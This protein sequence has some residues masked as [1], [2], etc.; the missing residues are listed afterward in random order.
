MTAAADNLLDYAEWLGIV[1]VLATL[2]GKEA[3][4]ASLSSLESLPEGRLA[5]LAEVGGRSPH[6]CA[7][8]AAVSAARAGVERML[9][10]DPVAQTTDDVQLAVLSVDEHLAVME[11]EAG[12]NAP[13]VPPPSAL[14][15]L[16]E[17]GLLLP[18]L[19]R[20]VA[21]GHP[22]A[23]D[24]PTSTIADRVETAVAVLLRDFPAYRRQL[25]PPI[26]D[27]SVLWPGPTALSAELIGVQ[28]TLHTIAAVMA[29]PEPG[30][31]L[32][33]L[34]TVG[35]D[36]RALAL[37][38][39]EL[40]ELFHSGGWP[41]TD[42][43]L[44]GRQGWALLREDGTSVAGADN[45]L[46]WESALRLVWGDGW[47]SWLR[48]AHEGELAALG[49]QLTASES[50]LPDAP[51]PDT[52]V[53]QVNALRGLLGKRALVLGGTARS[54]K[55][56]IVR[57][58]AGKLRDRSRKNLEAESKRL[59]RPD[60]RRQATPPEIWDIAVVASLTHVLP[61]RQTLLRV[62]QHALALSASASA[63]ATRKLLVLED[64]YPTGEGDV[65]DVLPY[66]SDRLAAD[67][68][69]VLEY[70]RNAHTDWK[71]DRVPVVT[72]IVGAEALRK[73]VNLLASAYPMTNREAGLAA[74]E[75][76]PPVRDLHHLTHLMAR[77]GTSAGR[78]QLDAEIEAWAGQL[79][80]AELRTVAGVAA[81]SLVRIRV[82]DAYVD[83]LSNEA[84]STLGM[85]KDPASGCYQI[86]D[87]ETCHAVLRIWRRWSAT[88]DASGSAP[89]KGH[90]ASPVEVMASLLYQDFIGPLLD[91]GHPGLIDELACIRLYG[92][93][94][95]RELLSQAR[96][97]LGWWIRT[98]G[99]SADVARLLLRLDTSV[100]ETIA[101]QVMNRL[102]EDAEHM[103]P[104]DSIEG[105]IVV[106]RCVHRRRAFLPP[107]SEDA[108]Y[109]WLQRQAELLLRRHDG[110]PHQR[111][112]LLTLLERLH[113][114][115][116]AEAVANLTIEVVDSVDPD[117]IEDYYLISRVRSL[118]LRA[119]RFLDDDVLVFPI[120]QETGVQR[121]LNRKHDT[122]TPFEII[123]GQMMIRREHEGGDWDS[124][125]LDNRTLLISSVRQT[126]AQAF[127]DSLNQLHSAK[128]LYCNALLKHSMYEGRT[129]FI[130]GI[131][132]LLRSATAIEA[133]AVIRA[134]ASSH[135]L[136]AR[137]ILFDNGI[138]DAELAK[139]LVNPKHRE[140]KGV[141]MLLSAVQQ[142]DD[143]YATTATFGDALGRA[144]GSQWV[145]EVLANDPRPSVRYHLLKGVWDAQLPI[146]EESLGVTAEVV[147][148]DIRHAS[149]EWAALLALRI[150]Q[151]DSLG[152]R[153]LEELRN[154]VSPDDVLRCMT[155]AATNALSSYHQLGRLL[156]P[157]TCDR[158]AACVD[159]E[160]VAHTI[161]AARGAAVAELCR[162][163]TRTLNDAGQAPTARRILELVTAD[164][165][166][167]VAW[168]DRLAAVG[169]GEEFVQLLSVLGDLDVDLA[170]RSL[171]EL[172]GRTRPGRNGSTSE[173]VLTLLVR[174]AMF[175]NA[176]SAAQMLAA[177]HRLGGAST[178]T[179]DELRANHGFAMTVFASELRTIQ[180]PRRL[181]LAAQAMASIGAGPDDTRNSWIQPTFTK[182]LIPNFSGPG[183]LLD[184][185]RT[186]TL[187]SPEIGRQAVGLI[188]VQRLSRRLEWGGCRADADDAVG[189]AAL[190]WQVGAGDRAIE[191]LDSFT[192]RGASVISSELS[193]P[194]K[195]QLI[196]LGRIH[197]QLLRD[198]APHLMVTTLAGLDRAPAVDVPA[199]LSAAGHVAYALHS[200]GFDHLPEAKGGG[201]LT[202]SRAAHRPGWLSWCLRWLP[203]SPAVQ[204]VYAAAVSQLFRSLGD[205][206]AAPFPALALASAESMA[207]IAAISPDDVMKMSYRQL[208]VLYEL[209][210]GDPV[211]A[212]LM[213]G[214]AGPIEQRAASVAARSDFAAW[215]LRE[216]LQTA[217][218]TR[219]TDTGS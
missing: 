47:D 23:K 169:N 94:L 86:W 109:R 171:E 59:A 217:P 50:P 67:V 36:G 208:V 66:V 31:H 40:K 182:D 203:R 212:Q 153:F 154:L 88:A 99:T 104:L 48:Q 205:I 162:E 160:E 57:L 32:L 132:N 214:I 216:L 79:I 181:Y 219:L 130:S 27:L 29:L 106:A 218:L 82:P 108:M 199:T 125:L 146:R 24:L 200:A 81:A 176:T 150:V 215:E 103:S 126:R 128:P 193:D 80:P 90:L 107:G 204:D 34:G 60:G 13:P 41:G 170:R 189:L 158:Y 35:P 1:G 52:E 137:Y 211:L 118:Q 83:D 5:E 116:L 178:S 115:Q 117:E 111:L 9:D 124:L 159:P 51:L 78:E 183:A 45:S 69:A 91:T 7:S 14:A 177:I 134:V 97:E 10:G 198:A 168:A 213:R 151:D 186:I 72:S 185:L 110:A 122:A 2:G 26:P 19:P 42:V 16:A 188:N 114:P 43:L 148:Y 163:V 11:S 54:G 195:V 149:T 197:P 165:D 63:S 131:R 191:I 33:A 201:L 85:S 184:V 179:Y 157:E 119:K 61:G 129:A 173:R 55:S 39:E 44:P 95:C 100:A 87:S 18:C 147:A 120:G 20:E 58:L 102:V 196:R 96:V 174:H 93:R 98:V 140:A 84:M 152:E 210:S 64:L 112:A 121:L 53:S 133:A 65:D 190:C 161:A 21:A 209:A 12:E 68:L 206:A 25:S 46:R 180:S 17:E 30:A 138:P 123:V 75:S 71:T 192:S 142:V 166:D 202:S 74:I 136:C 22:W 207:G 155:T 175:D 56:T 6:V 92:D 105:A 76:E 101:R 77:E 187:W 145:L 139:H 127:A 8:K 135:G 62:G 89:A 143:A 113:D 172:A 156:F 194:A 37:D 28:T 141:G 73:F 167:E 49:W 15:L 4:D 70:D 164:Q 144:L 38:D 3:P